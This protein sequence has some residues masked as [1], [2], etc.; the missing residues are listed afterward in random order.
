VVPHH[1]SLWSALELSWGLLS[2]AEREMLGAVAVFRGGFDLEAVQ[3]VL[4]GADG[5]P[6]LDRLQALREHSLLVTRPE[7]A[8]LRFDVLESIRDFGAAHLVEAERHLWEDRH[9]LYYVEAAEQRLS[10][11]WGR[12]RSD[13]LRWFAEERL[14]LLVAEERLSA[15]GP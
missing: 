10:S 9:A 14:N 4:G 8:G 11:L 6:L 15:R 5:P 1:A 12:G 7:A 13:V 3:S 2:E